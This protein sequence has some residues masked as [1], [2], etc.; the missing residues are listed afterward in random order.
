MLEKRSV[1]TPVTFF[2]RSQTP[3]MTGPFLAFQPTS[4]ASPLPGLTLE[5]CMKWRWQP[6]TVLA[7]AR[8]PWSPSV[9]VKPNTVPSPEFQRQVIASSGAKS[10]LLCSALHPQLCPS[11]TAAS[12]DLGALAKA[13]PFI[14]FHL[15]TF[16]SLWHHS[17]PPKHRGQ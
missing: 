17:I 13:L 16:E 10:H 11:A 9:Q 5:A 12:V 8:Q 7:R 3:L 2:S 6:T 15:E 14:T 4:T 1:L